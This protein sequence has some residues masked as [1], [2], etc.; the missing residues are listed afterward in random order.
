LLLVHSYEIVQFV[1]HWP[2]SGSGG[3]LSGSGGGSL[4]SGFEKAC[5]SFGSRFRR[6]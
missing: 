5:P 6:K 2:G 1:Q 4:F 3:L